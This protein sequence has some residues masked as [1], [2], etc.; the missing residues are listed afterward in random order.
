MSARTL[1]ELHG[2]AD[3]RYSQFSWRTRLALAH[4]GLNVDYR[5]VRVSDKAAIAFSGQDK[6]PILVEEA[7]TVIADS[8]RIAEHLEDRYADRPSLFGGPVGH[9]FARFINH[10]V[11]RTLVPK[12]APMLMADV[13]SCVDAADA[14]HLRTQI[15]RAF[16]KSLE[17]MRDERDAG[18]KDFRRSLDPARATLKAQPYLSGPAPAYPD[19]ILFSLLQWARI[20][21]EFDLIEA[22][23]AVLAAWRERMLDLFDGLARRA[24]ARK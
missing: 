23:D 5:P 1:F 15:E 14:T 4:K 21:S 8:W 12:A 13:I 10:W 7:G 2:L 9:G 19:Y 20:V 18:V 11:D 17:A 6:V 24:P 22:K 3:R 16:G